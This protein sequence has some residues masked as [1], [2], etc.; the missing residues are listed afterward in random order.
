MSRFSPLF[1]YGHGWVCYPRLFNPRRHVIFLRLHHR[2]YDGYE[3]QGVCFCKR[4]FKDYN[5][6]SGHGFAIGGSRMTTVRVSMVLQAVGQGW[7]PC[8]YGIAIGGSNN[9]T[10]MVL[11]AVDQGWQPYEYGIASG[12]SRMATV[13]VSMVLHAC[14]VDQG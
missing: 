14:A 3:Y 6:T 13:R 10:S 11:Q 9:R 7:Q 5:H 12:G 8:E 1:F 2:A 4:W